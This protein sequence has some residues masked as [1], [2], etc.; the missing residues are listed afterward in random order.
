MSRGSYEVRGG[1]RKF[2]FWGGGYSHVVERT[3]WVVIATRKPRFEKVERNVSCNSDLV[4]L[5]L[6]VISGV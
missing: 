4:F 6:V 1:E 3:A 5:C 2:F